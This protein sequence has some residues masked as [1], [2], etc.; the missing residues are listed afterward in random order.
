MYDAATTE[1]M[2][3]AEDVRQDLVAK[4]GMTHVCWAGCLDL[5]DGVVHSPSARW[6]SSTWALSRQEGCGRTHGWWDRHEDKDFFPTAARGDQRGQALAE[7]AAAT[8]GIATEESTIV[9][10]QSDRGAT[11]GE[12]TDRA[13]IAT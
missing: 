5:G 7:D 1:P 12:V 11:A 8:A 9:E 2:Q 6:S 13:G 10:P 4:F 3:V